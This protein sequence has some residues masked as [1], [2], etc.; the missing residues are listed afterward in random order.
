MIPVQYRDPETEEILERRHE[1]A[2]PAIGTRVQIG[3][4]QYQVLFR[5]RCVPTC[6]I[7]YVRRAPREVPAAASAA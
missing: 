7:V 6:C 1:E 5:W 2:V 4:G 3:F